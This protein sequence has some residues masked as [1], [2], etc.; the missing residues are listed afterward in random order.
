MILLGSIERTE[1]QAI[2]DWWLSPARRVFERSQSSPGHGSKVSWESFTFVDEEGGEES[3]D[4]VKETKHELTQQCIWSIDS[5]CLKNVWCSYT[6]CFAPR[7][8]QCR[9]NVMGPSH[10]QN[11][12]ITKAQVTFP[13]HI[14]TD[15][16]IKCHLL[17]SLTQVAVLCSQAK[18]KLPSVR[19]TLQRLFSSTSSASPTETQVCLLRS[20]LHT[21]YFDP[22]GSEGL[23]ITDLMRSC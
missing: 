16:S 2:F 1:L 6:L 3:T 21:Y 12:R 5:V 20:T 7:L 15:L 8:L 17:S 18:R 11:L 19:R 22:K 14:N 23:H 4:K 13:M 9:M 10:H